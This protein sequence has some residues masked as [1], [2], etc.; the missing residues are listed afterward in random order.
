MD[1]LVQIGF[2]DNFSYNNQPIRYEITKDG[3][4]RVYVKDCA[5]ALGRS[6]IEI[7][8]KQEYHSFRWQ[9]IYDDLTKCKILDDKFFR[10]D[11]VEKETTYKKIVESM[12]I[13]ENELYKWQ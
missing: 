11:L 7:K 8:N 2:S 6:K 9:R 10:P 5:I 1:E 13:Y 3:R 12:T 4:M